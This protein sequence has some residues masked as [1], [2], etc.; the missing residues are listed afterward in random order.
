VTFPPVPRR[1]TEYGVGA[2]RSAAEVRRGLDIAVG[3]RKRQVGMATPAAFLGLPKLWL[4]DAFYN[5]FKNVKSACLSWVLNSRKRFL[6]CS[7]SP[8]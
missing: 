8:P 4:I 3:G 1:V 7:A 5:E 2:A 6:T